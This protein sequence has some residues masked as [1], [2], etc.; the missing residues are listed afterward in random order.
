MS[1]RVLTLSR[2]R[3]DDAWRRKVKQT[4]QSCPCWGCSDRP[5]TADS[6]ICLASFAPPTPVPNEIHIIDLCS[7]S[8]CRQ[9][10]DR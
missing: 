9:V 8:L 7:R 1:N 4:Q 6:E 5:P 10:N 3:H 2:Q